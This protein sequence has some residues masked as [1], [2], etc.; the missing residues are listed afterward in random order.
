MPFVPRLDQ[1]AGK[2]RPRVPPRRR[3]IVIHDAMRETLKVPA[4]QHRTSRS[5]R[6]ATRRA[7]GLPKTRG[8]VTPPSCAAIDRSAEL[9]TLPAR[10]P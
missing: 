10:A 8:P 7:G 9:A 5:S 1:P 6:V 4:P 3:A 2:R